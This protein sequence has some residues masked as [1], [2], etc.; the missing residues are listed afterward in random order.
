MGDV[1]L[2]QHN[3]FEVSNLHEHYRKATDLYQ[4]LDSIR[5]WEEQ[6]LLNLACSGMEN[7]F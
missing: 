2:K 7:F 4:V 1:I 3:V 6:F 5:R